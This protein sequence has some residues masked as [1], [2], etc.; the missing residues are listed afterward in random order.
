MPPYSVCAALA[1]RTWQRERSFASAMPSLS[2]KASMISGSVI[3]SIITTDAPRKFPASS[4]AT[5][6]AEALLEFLD[7]AASTLIFD[8]PRGGEIH[9]GKLVAVFGLASGL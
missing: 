8:T 2:A 6:T 4:L 7:K 3:P 9:R 5:A 1:I